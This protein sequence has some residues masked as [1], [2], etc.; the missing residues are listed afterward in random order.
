MS[1][2]PAGKTRKR[3]GKHKKSKGSPQSGAAL[4]IFIEVR[5]LYFLVGDALL[6]AGLQR[7]LHGRFQLFQD[8]VAV[9]D[10]RDVSHVHLLPGMKKP[11]AGS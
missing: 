11:P 9:V 4:D 5:R 7:G 2:F 6:P 1:S 3:T 10:D 8:L